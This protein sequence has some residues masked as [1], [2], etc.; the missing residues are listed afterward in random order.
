MG[1]RYDRRNG[2]VMNETRIAWQDTAKIKR[3]ATKVR[4][5]VEKDLK[6]DECAR[7]AA[8]RGRIGQYRSHYEC[9]VDYL[10]YCELL[11]ELGL[12][13][14]GY[15]PPIHRVQRETGIPCWRTVKRCVE[16]ARSSAGGAGVGG[17]TGERAGGPGRRRSREREA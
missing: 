15:A 3:P 9:V 17:G 7:L 12:K 1:F 8:A 5:R 4:L 11:V 10:Q 16:K 13:P 2:M 6:P 14:A